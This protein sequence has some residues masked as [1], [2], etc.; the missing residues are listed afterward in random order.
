MYVD[1]VITDI[2]YNDTAVKG[3]TKMGKK[4]LDSVLAR[5]QDYVDKFLWGAGYNGLEVR[6]NGRLK[7]SLGRFVETWGGDMYIELN[8]AQVILAEHLDGQENILDT[9]R[10]EMTHYE[11]LKDG[12]DNRDGAKD[13]E[14]KLAENKAASSG[15]TREALKV[16][17]EHLKYYNVIDVYDCISNY[18]QG[19]LGKYYKAHTDKPSFVGHNVS[20]KGV[21]VTMKRV[22][23]QIKYR[24]G[25]D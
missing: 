24:E 4:A 8:K 22:G 13:F 10:H 17:A 9:L 11:V 15:T 23:F 7:D 5:Y 18:G 1:K 12:G 14:K 25:I 16:S 2:A 19:S 21:P 3:F 6:L 20:V